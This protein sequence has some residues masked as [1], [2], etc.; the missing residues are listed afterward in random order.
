MKAKIVQ[1]CL[2]DIIKEDPFPNK[3]SLTELRKIWDDEQYKYTDDELMRIRE[4]IYAIA[5]IAI[6]LEGEKAANA[7]KEEAKTV[8]IYLSKKAC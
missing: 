4:W 3:V 6:R 2:K 7:D 8:P 5:A 1:L